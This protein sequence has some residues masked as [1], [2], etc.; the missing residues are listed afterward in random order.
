MWGM[1]RGSASAFIGEHEIKLTKAARS[2][3]II[4]HE[5]AHLL[6]PRDEAHGP[7]FVGV[8][9]GLLARH[10]GQD[11]NELMVLADEMGVRYHIRSVGAVPVSKMH[12]RLALLLPVNYMMA[13][14]QLDVSY[15]VVY[16][17]ALPLI[18]A[19]RARWSGRTL[20]RAS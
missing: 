18:R 16:G 2:Q 15:R 13:A 14:I 19:K 10:A 4:L 8:L 5:M 1:S 20:V 12:E 7:R 9:I 3:W 11:A 17:A 6:C